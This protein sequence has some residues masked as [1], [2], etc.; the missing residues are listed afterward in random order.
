MKKEDRLLEGDPADE[1]DKIKRGESQYPENGLVLKSFSRD[2]DR[3][4]LDKNDW[5]TTAWNWDF[6]WFN[7]SEAKSLMPAKL[8]KDTEW[9]MP[10]KL[11]RR[12]YRIYFRDNVRG[13]TG[14]YSDS[15]IETATLKFKIKKMKRKGIEIEIEGIVKIKDGTRGVEGKIIGEAVYDPAKNRFTKFELVMTGERWGETQYNARKDD[16]ERAPIGFAMQMTGDHPVDRIAPS[17]LG[18][19][20]W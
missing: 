14:P 18:A 7:E 19:Y 1:K 6:V 11:V 8:T 17:H 4:G 15:S 13:Q 16:T 3:K 2:L 10:E 9:V 12:L 20:G 5:R